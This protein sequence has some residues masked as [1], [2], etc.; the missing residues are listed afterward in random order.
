MTDKGTAVT[1]E[2][3]PDGHEHATVTMENLGCED[4]LMYI[5]PRQAIPIIFVPGIMGTPLLATGDNQGLIRHEDGKWSW[6]PDSLYWL[7]ISM[8][9]GGFNRL[10]PEQKKALLDPRN[11]KVPKAMGEANFSGLDL[12]KCILPKAEM[13]RRGWG[14]IILGKHG[15]GSIVNFLEKELRTL[16]HARDNNKSTLKGT[17]LAYQS[18]IESINGYEPLDINAYKKASAWSYPVYAFGYNWLRSNDESAEE[19]SKYIDFVLFDCTARLKLKCSQVILVTHSMGGLVARRCAQKHPEHILGIVHGVQPAIGAATAYRRVRAGWEDL[20]G[21]LAIGAN[22]REVTPIFASPGPLQ[23]LPNQLYG[24]NW[25][26]VHWRTKEASPLMSLPQ[27]NNPY[28]EIYAN[29]TSWWRLCDPQLV[30]PRQKTYDKIS[31]AWELYLKHLKSAENFHADLGNYYFPLTYAHYGTDKGHPAWNKIQWVI[32][33]V[34]NAT[35]TYSNRP[36]V[37]RTPH[38]KLTADNQANYVILKNLATAGKVA[39]QPLQGPAVIGADY[40]GDAYRAAIASPDDSGD[41]TVPTHSADAL[42]KFV[43]FSAKL[44]GFDHA[45]SYDN[46]T[47]RAVTLHSIISLSKDAKSLCQI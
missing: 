45:H 29:T 3:G 12:D 15:Y 26:N 13:E 28:K 22:A 43:K 42:T 35:G 37:D 25:L 6:F 33:G 7:G 19:L 17:M 23:L 8:T 31:E 44:K 5:A 27:H 14:S 24:N 18:E 39:Y 20:A 47:V 46:K 1:T 21:R 11:T 40:A 9:T 2:I 41:G 38:L 4:N 10:S 16:Y 34:R 36:P 30:D 32:E